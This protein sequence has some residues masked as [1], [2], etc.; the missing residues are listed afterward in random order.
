MQ[1]FADV[2]PHTTLL[3]VDGHS[4]GAFDFVSRISMM[5]RLLHMK[6]GE[7]LFCQDALQQAVHIL[8]G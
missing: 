2:A 4:V 1:T 6:G 3:S 5:Q 8:V 7:K